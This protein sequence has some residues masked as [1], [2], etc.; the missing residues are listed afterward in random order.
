MDYPIKVT[1]RD[2]NGTYQCRFPNGYRSSSTHSA[3]V[4]AER[5]MDKVW[6]PGTHRASL[7]GRDGDSTFFEINPIR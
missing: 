5:L 4:A 2:R 3:E 7:I 6:P 1:V